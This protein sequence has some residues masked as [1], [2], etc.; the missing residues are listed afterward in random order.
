MENGQHMKTGNE[1]VSKADTSEDSTK[2]QA[3]ESMPLGESKNTHTTT[4][5]NIQ[6]GSQKILKSAELTE[7]Q[8]RI[9]LVAAALSDFQEAKGRVI[10]REIPYTMPNG[11]TFTALKIF[12]FIEGASLVA[13]KTSDG[14]EFKVL[15]LGKKD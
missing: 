4:P 14:T 5:A 12:V 1:S 9:G 2:L 8:S 15:P 11:S 10:A 7:L 13:E 3:L 6:N